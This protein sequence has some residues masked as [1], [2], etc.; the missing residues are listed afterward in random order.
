MLL[1]ELNE[2]LICKAQILYWLLPSNLIIS[3]FQVARVAAVTIVA[4]AGETVRPV[5]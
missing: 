1:Y 2:D 5:T 4:T 3:G